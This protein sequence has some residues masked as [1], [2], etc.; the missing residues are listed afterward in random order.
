MFFSIGGN[1][2]DRAAAWNIPVVNHTWLEDCFAQWK[3]ITPAVGKYLHFPHNVDFAA[4]LGEKGI[5]RATLDAETIKAE[6]E[7]LEKEAGPTKVTKPKSLAK[8]ASPRKILPDVNPADT[9]VFA[10][11]EMDRPN[12]PTEEAG[13]S[14]PTSR[15]KL[16]RRSG[17]RRDAESLFEVEGLLSGDAAPADTNEDTPQAST[18]RVGRPTRRGKQEKELEDDTPEPKAAAPKPKTRRRAPG[19][20][21]PTS[22]LKEHGDDAQSDASAP[23]E[24]LPAT[25]SARASTINS[26][27]KKTPT[28]PRRRGS[29]RENDAE[30]AGAPVTP[31]TPR[32]AFVE[33][34]PLSASRAPPTRNE[35][36][37]ITADEA[38]PSSSKRS[39]PIPSPSKTRTKG[40]TTAADSETDDDEPLSDPPLS[41]ARKRPGPKKRAAT[42]TSSPAP[43]VADTSLTMSSQI[44]GNGRLRRGAAMRAD[45]K[46]KSDMEDLR[47]FESQRRR[48][49][50]T[51][52]WEKE[53]ERE[54][55]EKEK[56]QAHGGK[57][58]RAS[59]GAESQD[60][61]DADGDTRQA[62]KRKVGP[63]KTKRAVKVESEEEMD[64]EESASKA[65]A[66]GYESSIRSHLIISSRPTSSSKAKEY[67][68]LTSQWSMT[69]A[70][71]KVC[72]TT[73]YS[74]HKTEHMGRIWENLVQLSRTATKHAPISS[75]QS[76]LGRRNFW[77]C[78]PPSSTL[79]PRSG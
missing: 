28:T 60:E 43:E 46:L 53:A 79:F 73:W 65:P 45:N 25:S 5:G 50:I 2:A 54:A 76:L 9:S 31:K 57:K 15:K 4:Q 21:K 7:T 62:K 56:E 32:R 27:G 58:K 67:R 10:E 71:E 16:V 72:E 37:R 40:K 20:V 3:N 48:G 55:K 17:S 70:Q 14:Q 34:P 29:D 78:C 61:E 66:K 63:P 42:G 11:Q 19:A 47:Q 59:M 77:R 44:D 8:M 24:I 75:C 39:K 26:P 52:S 49:V 23:L 74:S 13:S 68:I 35:S 36:I 64:I 12:S 6:L 18:S 33:V 30:M 41:P 51:G 38:M 1:K 22:N 69:T